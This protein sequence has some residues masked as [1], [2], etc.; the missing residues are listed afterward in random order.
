MPHA[1]DRRPRLYLLSPPPEQIGHDFCAQLEDALSGGDIAAFLAP[2][3]GRG[4]LDTDG[5]ADLIRRVQRQNVAALVENDAALGRALQADGVHLKAAGGVRQARAA[6]GDGLILG[7]CCG[8]SRH[9][10]MAA[11]EG[12]AD[13]VAFGCGGGATADAPGFGAAAIDGLVEAVSWWSALMELPVVAWLDGEKAGNVGVAAGT[14][15]AG[16]DLSSLDAAARLVQAGADFL[17]VG[18]WV[19]RGAEGPGAAVKALNAL[20]RRMATKDKTGT[21]DE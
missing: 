7:A 1:S 10:A 8:L 20:C 4:A 19:W 18:A 3:P 9:E 12:G 17:A 13:Y 15:V 14:G 2:T 16:L 5:V 21:A 6:L 11:G